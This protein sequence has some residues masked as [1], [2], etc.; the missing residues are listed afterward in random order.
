MNVRYW[1]RAEI[2]IGC[3]LTLQTATSALM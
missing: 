3:A 2:A 1:G